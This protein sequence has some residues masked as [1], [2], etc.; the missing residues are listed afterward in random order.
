MPIPGHD[1]DREITFL[2]PLSNFRYEGQKHSFHGYLILLAAATLSIMDI[3]SI[4]GRIA[5]F[6]RDGGRKDIISK[7]FWRTAILGREDVPNDFIT[8]Y[9]GLIVEEPE[10]FEEAELKAVNDEGPKPLHIRR[11][12]DI[13]PL[14]TQGLEEHTVHWANDVHDHR[15]HHRGQS[16]TSERTLL[17]MPSP[18]KQYSDDTLHEM[19]GNMSMSPKAPLLHRIARS[20]FSTLERSLIFAGFFQL[21]TGIVVYTGGC[22]ENYINGCLAHLISKYNFRSNCNVVALTNHHNCRGWYFL[23]LRFGDFRPISRSL[24]GARMGLESG[25][26]WR[27]SQC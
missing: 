16:A 18:T 17:G 7:R 24:F 13:V 19:D 3:I 20:A 6:V 15:H 23:V 14:Q 8:E 9:T 10:E 22:R 2:P 25:T 4:V 5:A 21:L 1:A 12:Q 27:L 26:S 11:N